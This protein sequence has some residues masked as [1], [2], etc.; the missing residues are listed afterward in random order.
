MELSC[1][2]CTQCEIISLLLKSYHLHTREQYHPRRS[3]VSLWISCSWKPSSHCVLVK[4][5]GIPLYD[6]F[7]NPEYRETGSG[8]KASNV[9]RRDFNQSCFNIF[10]LGLFGLASSCS[11]RCSLDTG[12]GE[13]MFNF[14]LDIVFQGV[15]VDFCH[16]FSNIQS[17]LNLGLCKKE[18]NG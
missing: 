15:V 5:S 10:L 13:L 18:T 8:N 17:S 11:E 7:L 4:H 2:C 14:R 1:C 16:Q 6:Q 9:Y 12:G 3:S